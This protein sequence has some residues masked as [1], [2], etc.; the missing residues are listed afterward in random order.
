[1]LCVGDI[2]EGPGDAARTLGLLREHE[3]ECVRGNHDRWYLR[4]TMRDLPDATGFDALAEDARAWIEALPTTRSYATPRGPLLLCHG[5]GSDDMATVRPDDEGYALSSNGALG[6]L[7]ASTR[8]RWIVS[9]HSHRRM[10][11]RFEDVTFINAGTLFRE[12]DPCFA[13]I[14]FDAGALEFRRPAPNALLLESIK[15]PV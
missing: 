5:L 4:G 14:D 8:H 12:H 11:R 13:V 1:M 9:G 15:L 10:V 6:D 3:V 7:L 2:V